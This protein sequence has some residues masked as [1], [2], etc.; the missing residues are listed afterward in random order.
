METPGQRSSTHVGTES[1]EIRAGI[2]DQLFTTSN[3]EA[4]DADGD[5]R[6]AAEAP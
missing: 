3:L 1:Y 2:P 5:R 4:G 6:A